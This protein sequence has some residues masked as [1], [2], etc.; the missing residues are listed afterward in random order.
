MSRPIACQSSLFELDADVA[1]DGVQVDR[2]V[3]RAADGRI[4]DDGV[5]ERGA[6]HDLD[7]RRSS[8][9]HVDDAL[10]GLIGHLRRSR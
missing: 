2:R 5:F 1:G 4:D 6:R 7:G 8:Q 10:A 3:G 9:H